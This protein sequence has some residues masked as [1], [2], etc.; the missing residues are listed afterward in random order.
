[1]H[2]TPVRICNQC[3]PAMTES[4]AKNLGP[5]QP[6]M[7]VAWQ[8]WVIPRF[9]D[10]LVWGQRCRDLP[11]DM[12]RHARCD[13]CGRDDPECVLNINNLH[14]QHWHDSCLPSGQLVDG[15]LLY[16]PTQ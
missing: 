16:C 11:A 5:T 10:K 9:V 1:M 4:Q 3:V 2:M 15:A 7:D 13:K 8:A 6:Y 12:P 14:P